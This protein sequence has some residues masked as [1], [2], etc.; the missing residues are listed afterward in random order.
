MAARL[1]LRI[2]NETNWPASQRE[3]KSVLAVLDGPD[4]QEE[5]AYRKRLEEYYHK[6]S[7]KEE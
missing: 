2:A 4:Y 1:S 5:K 7:K 3:E 6:N